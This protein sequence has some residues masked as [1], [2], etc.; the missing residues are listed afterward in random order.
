MWQSASNNPI[1]IK[2]YICF[3][4]QTSVP[5]DTMYA[6][7]LQFP[8]QL[9]L[10]QKN[11]IRITKITKK[12]LGTN[13]QSLKKQVT[14]HYQQNMAGNN[15]RE[16]YQFIFLTYRFLKFQIKF[17]ILSLAGQKKFDSGIHNNFFLQIYIFLFHY[18]LFFFYLLF[19]LQP[20]KYLPLLFYIIYY[21]GYNL[22]YWM[23]IEVF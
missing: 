22:L 14:R 15:K 18:L 21:I 9:A 4:K 16:K 20:L 19:F 3:E 13:D 8:T 11:Q 10:T 12:N 1:V 7:V 17:T 2:K 23:Y 6:I 5:N